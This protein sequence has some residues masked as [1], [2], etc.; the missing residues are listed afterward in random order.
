[1]VIECSDYLVIHTLPRPGRYRRV[2]L[3]HN[4]K[5]VSSQGLF[6]MLE[7]LCLTTHFIM[8]FVNPDASKLLPNCFP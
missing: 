1:M 6:K 4:F 7:T 8:V 5:A 3:K 2:T